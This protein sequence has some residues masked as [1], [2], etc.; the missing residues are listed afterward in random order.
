M[1][2][3]VVNRYARDTPDHPALLAP[4]D[5]KFLAT[6]RAKMSPT[7][8]GTEKR[9]TWKSAGGST[10]QGKKNPWKRIK[11]SSPAEKTENGPTVPWEAK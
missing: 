1:S 7:R 10:Q 9:R 2:D 3:C 8:W 5:R 4:P 6:F 11:E